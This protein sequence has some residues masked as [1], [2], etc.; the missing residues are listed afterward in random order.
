MGT[1]AEGLGRLEDPRHGNAGHHFLH[2]ILV[3]AWCTL[4]Y[5]GETR[6]DM[7]L[8]GQS[9]REFLESCLPLKN[10]IPSHY[11]FSMVFRL[12]DPEAFQKWFLSFMAAVCPR[13]RGSAGPGRQDAAPFL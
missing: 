11:P 6:S 9:K 12:W 8:F 7:A 2:N 13:L 10:G 5:G 1:L 4:L 3:I